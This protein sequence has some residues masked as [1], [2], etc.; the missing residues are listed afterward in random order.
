MTCDDVLID[1]MRRIL[2]RREGCSE[3]RMFGTTC[4]MIHDNMCAAAWKGSLIVR[5]DKQN[6]DATLA[7]PYTRPADMNGRTMKGWALVEPAG[8][9]SDDQLAVWLGRAAKFAESLP[10]KK[11]DPSHTRPALKQA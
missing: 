9:A 3:G 8:F 6:H 1:R 7:E 10:A 2:S 4:F 11:R 5:L